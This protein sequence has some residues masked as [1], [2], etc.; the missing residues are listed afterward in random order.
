MNQ[1][2]A[3]DIILLPNSYNSFF[4]SKFIMSGAHLTVSLLLIGV[5]FS[6]VNSEET[7]E[8]DYEV[9]DHIKDFGR[10]L[11]TIE[12]EDVYH[13]EREK[14]LA[15]LGPQN[16]SYVPTAWE[17]YDEDRDRTTLSIE[18]NLL[19]MEEENKSPDDDKDDTDDQGQSYDSGSR[20]IDKKINVPLISI[21]PGW[22]PFTFDFPTPGE[23]AMRYTPED[24]ARIEYDSMDK[25]D[26]KEPLRWDHLIHHP[27]MMVVDFDHTITNFTTDLL[28]EPLRPYEGN[29]PG[30]VDDQGYLFVPHD[31]VVRVIEAVRAKGVKVALIAKER[32]PHLVT[33]FLKHTKLDKLFDYVELYPSD[34]E[35]DA[36][37]YFK[38]LSAKCKIPI[39]DMIYI[40]ENYQSLQD[41][42]RL[43]ATPQ[44]CY[45]T[46]LTMKVVN[47]CL[48]QHNQ[49]NI[50]GVLPHKLFTATGIPGFI[51]EEFES[52]E[53]PF[54]LS[55]MS[56]KEYE[57][58]YQ[59]HIDALNKR[60]KPVHPPFPR[61]TK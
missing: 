23:L 60:L 14:V 24:E 10:P 5:C 4:S 3:C 54:Y 38:A 11:K 22:T 25:A 61:W 53:N 39:R 45:L 35:N 56:P 32:R 13:D 21:W 55:T 15:A 48:E 40:D 1:C 12:P 37:V 59:K 7:T 33:D 28:F 41:A 18:A 44:R 42:F 43:G 51:R 20:S 26:P 50:H 2:G 6:V 52:K 58:E 9:P 17:H 19:R 49:F 27:K 16:T 46:G 29:F 31:D 47:Q 30:A 57:K 34:D 8:F 36:G